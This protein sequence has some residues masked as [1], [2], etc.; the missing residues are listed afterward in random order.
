MSEVLSQSELEIL[1]MVMIS[2]GFIIFLVGLFMPISS[3][4]GP[5][6]RGRRKKKPVMPVGIG[7]CTLGVIL[8]LSTNIL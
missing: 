5:E 8:G 3:S 1:V 4:Y 2:G 6:L 7:L